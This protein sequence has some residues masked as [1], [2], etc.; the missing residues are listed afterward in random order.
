MPQTSINS[1]TTQKMIDEQ[2]KPDTFT[3]PIHTLLGDVRKSL[4]QLLETFKSQFAQDETGIGTTHLTQIQIN[5]DDSQP[6]LQRPYPIAMK[7][8]DCVRN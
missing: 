6:V 3:S 8:Y 7:H 5:R 1:L 2:V 4:Y